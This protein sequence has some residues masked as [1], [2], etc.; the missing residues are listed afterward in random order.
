[1]LFDLTVEVL[2]GPNRQTVL[3][4]R[5]HVLETFPATLSADV[6]ERDVFVQLPMLHR[7]LSQ[8]VCKDT[9]KL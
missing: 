3:R 6:V 8:F 9:K 7:R 1:M 5:F 2:Q 4:E